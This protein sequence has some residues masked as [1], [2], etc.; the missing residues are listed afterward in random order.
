MAEKKPMNRADV[1]LG[2][3][4]EPFRLSPGD[5]NVWEFERDATPAQLTRLLNTAQKLRPMATKSEDEMNQLDFD[6]ALLDEVSAAL[7]ELLVSEVQQKAWV[8]R[9][10]GIRTLTA[11]MPHIIE[12]VSGKSRPTSPP[13]SGKESKPAG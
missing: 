13:V 1:D 8:E 3:N 11:M 12:A 5:G 6:F 2:L 9:A 10:Y 4:F 7:S